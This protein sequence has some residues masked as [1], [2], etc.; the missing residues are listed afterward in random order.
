M[1]DLNHRIIVLSGSKGTSLW[2][3]VPG[4]SLP[5]DSWWP[6]WGGETGRSVWRSSFQEMVRLLTI[7][8]TVWGKQSHGRKGLE[9]VINLGK[10]SNGRQISPL[11]ERGLE[12]VWHSQNHN[13][14][15]QEAQVKGRLPWAWKPQPQPRSPLTLTQKNNLLKHRSQQPKDFQQE[16]DVEAWLSVRRVRRQWGE[17][18]K[19]WF[20]TRDC[21]II[22]SH[23]NPR[24][25]GYPVFFASTY[26]YILT[27][28][29]CI[30]ENKL[31]VFS[32]KS[33]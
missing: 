7:S 14:E 32:F 9:E 6:S 29:G 3:L 19:S 24:L 8:M 17:L 1:K 31:H 20:L 4:H 11:K 2:S 21:V 5:G 30:W 26:S 12:R 23:P 16:T 22:T 25:Q 15:T 10:V 28:H 33:W 13:W 27:D 18:E